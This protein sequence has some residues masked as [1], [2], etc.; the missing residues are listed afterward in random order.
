MGASSL[1]EELEV[2]RG[3]RIEVIP[4]PDG[5]RLRRGARVGLVRLGGQ[6]VSGVDGV[7]RFEGSYWGGIGVEVVATVEEEE[8]LEEER[9][10][11]SLELAMVWEGGWRAERRGRGREVGRDAGRDGGPEGGGWRVEE[12]AVDNEPYEHFLSGTSCIFQWND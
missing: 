3:Q 11:G 9:M 8:M 7:I 5:E 12:D 2:W 6:V 10:W 4:V 1:V